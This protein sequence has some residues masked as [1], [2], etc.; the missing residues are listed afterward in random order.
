[1]ADTAVH[2]F[3]RKSVLA[4]LDEVY[5]VQSPYASGD[6]RKSQWSDIKSSLATQTLDGGTLAT[7]S[8]MTL[9]QTLNAGAVNFTG[10]V[11]NLVDT[12]SGATSMFVD[13]Q[14]GGSSKFSVMK[15]GSV[16]TPSLSNSAGSWRLTYASGIILTTAGK[17]Y[18][19]PSSGIVLPGGSS[20][21]WNSSASDGS[22]VAADTVLARDAAGVLAQRNG[23]NAQIFNLYNTFTDASNYERLSLEWFSNDLY[24]HTNNAGSGSSRNILIR[25]SGDLHLSSQGGDNWK[26][27][28]GNFLAVTDNTYDIGAAGGNRPRNIFAGTIIRVDQNGR[29]DF[30]QKVLMSSPSTG[31]LTLQDWATT[32]FNLIQFGGT[33]SSFPALKRSAA[34]LQARLADDSGYAS[35]ASKSLAT[36]NSGTLTIATGVITATGSYHL[37]DTEGAAASDDL[38]TINGTVD[39]QFLVIRAADTTHTVVA[40]DGTGNLKLAGDFTMDNSEDTLLLWS[41]GTNLY[42]ISRSD[43][44]A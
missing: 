35:L 28:S 16:I 36:P 37:I 6:D 8:P 31:I 42:E 41:D 1:M 4:D 20:L 7:S 17:S 27:V 33:S 19:M 9:K 40:K 23:T 38:D 15:D 21:G 29:F 5:L 2:N 12:A 43:N 26:I 13:F 44:G 18:Y 11:I 3:T 30:D 32:S 24:I 22:A 25:A 39:G 10:F 14:I 34:T